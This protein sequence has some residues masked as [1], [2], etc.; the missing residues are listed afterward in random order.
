LAGR[1]RRDTD[2]KCDV[3]FTA[4]ELALRWKIHVDSLARYRSNGKGPAFVRVEGSIRYRLDD[5]EN[6]EREQTVK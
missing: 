4:D 1:R 3:L 2:L 5:I 6:Y